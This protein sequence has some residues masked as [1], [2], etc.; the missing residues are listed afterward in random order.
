MNKFAS[1]F[2]QWKLKSN[3]NQTEK[4]GE[5]NTDRSLTANK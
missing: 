1:S 4:K 3:L 5:N 2:N